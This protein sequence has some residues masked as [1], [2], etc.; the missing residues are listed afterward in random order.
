M[1]SS[2]QMWMVLDEGERD[3]RVFPGEGLFLDWV[4]SWIGRTLTYHS[5]S[6][7]FDPQHYTS[8]V[9]HGWRQEDWKFRVNGSY[10]VNSRPLELHE[11]LLRRERSGKGRLPPSCSRTLRTPS[12]A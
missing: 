7:G 11:T 10:A 12:P 6:P 4:C 1:V 8:W 5:Q 2:L 3:A 9:T